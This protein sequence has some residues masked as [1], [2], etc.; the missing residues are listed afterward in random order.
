MS[1]ENRRCRA[2]WRTALC[3][4]FLPALVACSEGDARQGAA[5]AAPAAL[6]VG[7]VEASLQEVPVAF[8]AVGRTEGSREVQVRA[9]VAGQ[10][11][12]RHEHV[13]DGKQQPGPNY[14]AV[15]AVASCQSK[16]IPIDPRSVGRRAGSM[17]KEPWRY[18]V[19]VPTTPPERLRSRPGGG[20]Q[21]RRC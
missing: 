16:Q 15:V 12:H 13:V 11:F 3:A 7:T 5:K 1:K 18:R 19:T 20:R 8:E 14:S 2:S 21:P 10:V 6:P 17:V 9:R 4:L